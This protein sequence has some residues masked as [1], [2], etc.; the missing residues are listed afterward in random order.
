MPAGATAA[1]NTMSGAQPRLGASARQRAAHG[2]PLSFL[3]AT[4]AV[5]TI[6]WFWPL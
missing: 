4:I 6:L 2:V 3:V 5:P 1:K